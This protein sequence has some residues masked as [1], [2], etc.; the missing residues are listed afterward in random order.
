MSHACIFLVDYAC[1]CMCVTPVCTICMVCAVYMHNHTQMPIIHDKCDCACIHVCALLCS[2]VL[3]YSD[4]L[5]SITDPPGYLVSTFN[6]QYDFQ[7]MSHLLNNCRWQRGLFGWGRFT[8][9]I[10]CIQQLAQ[11]RDRVTVVISVM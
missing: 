9:I 4:Q 8:M 5:F 6:T 11:V 3:T 7:T 2:C 10:V 1:A